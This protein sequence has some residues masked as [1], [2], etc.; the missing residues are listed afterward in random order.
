MKK[1]TLYFGLMLVSIANFAQ[2]T[3]TVDN[4]PG[5]TAQFSLLQAAHDAA[6]PG[7]FIYIHPSTTN[8]GSLFIK[9]RINLRGIG[10]NP[11][12]ANGEYASVNSIFFSSNSSQQTTGSGSSISGLTIGALGAA[13]D[14]GNILDVSIQNNRIN[15]ISYSNDIFNWLIQGNVLGGTSTNGVFSVINLGGSGVIGTHAN[16]VISHNIIIDK[17]GSA[18]Y[19]INGLFASDTFSNNLIIL[20]SSNNQ[21]SKSVFSSCNTP[22]VNNNIF[23]ITNTNTL[24]TV[25]G[26][27]NSTI[28]FQNCLTFA[29]AGQTVTALNGTNNLNNTNP[30]FINIDNPANPSFAYTKSYKLK[31]G[32]SAIGAGSDGSDLGIY[33]QGFKFQMKGYPFD[34]PYPTAMNINNAIVEAGGNLEVV[35][36]AS[37]N[38]EN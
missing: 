14:A 2:T 19:T 8:Y 5:T 1:F 26:T 12:L 31:V 35:F 23:L 29:Y 27:E 38:V 16:T 34:L 28:N 11:E 22:I 13:S 20:E 17:L 10:H 32:S 7:D 36:K 24:T 25:I 9:K 3:W 4:R 37:A 18:G 21:T 6:E 30:Q 15:N 33:G